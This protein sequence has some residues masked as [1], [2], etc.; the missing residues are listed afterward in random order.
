MNWTTACEEDIERRVSIL[1]QAEIAA[2]R[3]NRDAARRG[4]ARQSA[5]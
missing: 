5:R 1:Y 2:Q 4:P 3:P